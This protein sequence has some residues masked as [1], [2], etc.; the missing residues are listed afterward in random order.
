MK[1]R[2]AL[3]LATVWTDLEHT[4]LSERL[5]TQATWCVTPLMRNIQNRHVHRDRKWVPG[6][7]GLG[8][9]GMTAD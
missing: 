5:D 2:E 8:G 9:G 7:Q 1:R 6:C 4:T 3:T